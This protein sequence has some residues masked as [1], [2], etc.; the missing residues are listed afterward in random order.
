MAMT[1]P[2]GTFTDDFVASLKTF[3]G[4]IFGW[5]VQAAA[6]NNAD[7]GYGGSGGFVI[8]NFDAAA[9]IHIVLM[10]SDTPMTTPANVEHLGILVPSNEEA[11]ELRE[12]VQRYAEKDDRCIVNATWDEWDLEGD[13]GYSFD[14]GFVARYRTTGFNVKYLMPVAWDVSCN[15]WKPG[16]ELTDY[17]QYVRSAAPLSVPG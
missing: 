6:S 4:D 11:I 16:C 10:E 2:K 7:D 13:E 15:T 8:I 9:L 3:Y 14:A 17:W 1:Y 5:D 12:K